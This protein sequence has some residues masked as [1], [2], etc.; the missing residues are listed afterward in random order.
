MLKALWP[1]CLCAGTTIVTSNSA[2]CDT[3]LHQCD[4]FAYIDCDSGSQTFS[5]PLYKGLALDWCLT[6]EQSCGQAAAD[7]FCKVN[8]FSQAAS[9]Q[10]PVRLN[11]G[12]TVL[13]KSGAICNTDVHGCDTFSSVTCA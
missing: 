2:T 9:F 6:F 4:T 8:G 12:K 13:P 11:G 3:D 10:G 7:F 5:S 1:V